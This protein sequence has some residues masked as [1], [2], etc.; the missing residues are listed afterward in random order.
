VERDLGIGHGTVSKLIRDKKKFQDDTFCG[1]GNIRPSER[2]FK[3]L[4]KEPVST[5]REFEILKK[6]GLKTKRRTRFE[7]TTNS[8]HSRKVS[9]NLV[10]HDFGADVADQLWFSDIAYIQTL[11]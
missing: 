8:K 1:S 3:F 9:P 7:K 2:E 6:A 4:Q 10:N 5:K 11:K